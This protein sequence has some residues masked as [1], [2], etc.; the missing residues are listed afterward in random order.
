MIGSNESLYQSYGVCST[1]IS[2]Y[3]QLGS[4]RKRITVV[5]SNER[6]YEEIAGVCGECLSVV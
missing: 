2:S 5:K 1:T 6:D 4:N 3:V